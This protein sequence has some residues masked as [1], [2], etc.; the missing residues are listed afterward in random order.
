MSTQ[1]DAGFHFEANTLVSL[2]EGKVSEGQA[3][4]LI[5]AATVG[6]LLDEE[7]LF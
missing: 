3:V 1:P 7:S 5:G 2:R 4:C 6:V